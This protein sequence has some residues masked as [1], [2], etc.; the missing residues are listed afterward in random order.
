MLNGRAARS[1]Y[2]WFTLGQTLILVAMAIPYMVAPEALSDFDGRPT[3]T[4]QRLDWVITGIAYVLTVPLITVSVRR[5]HDLG[6]S[7]WWFAALFA[8]TLPT[9]F[10]PENITFARLFLVSMAVQMLICVYKGTD[11]PNRFGPDPLK[12]DVS[13]FE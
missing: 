13:V 12:P 1:E 8:F 6:L 11:G 10:S 3:A 7:G 5:F 4:S 2:W 9:E